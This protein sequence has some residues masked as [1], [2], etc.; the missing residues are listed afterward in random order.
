MG[1]A[2]DP[3]QRREETKHDAS[4]KAAD[5]LLRKVAIRLEQLSRFIDDPEDGETYITSVQFKVNAAWDGGVL[6]IVKA[7]RGEVAIVGFHSDDTLLECV[8]GLG[9][10]IAN[11][12]LKWKED[13]PY[14]TRNG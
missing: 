5:L 13:V 4:L 8:V 11:G 1:R 10:R 7:V 9:N 3:T 12:S 2:S 14:G 6:A